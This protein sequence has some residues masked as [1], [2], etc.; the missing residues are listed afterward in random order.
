V[1]DQRFFYHS[2][3]RRG[4]TL[5]I[6]IDKGCKIL[7]A[8]RDFGLILVPEY[9]VW[10]QPTT[11]GTDRLFPILQKRVCFTELSP[12][13][14]FQH[15]QKF[16][17]FALEFEAATIRKLGAIPVFYLPQPLSASD[18]NALGVALLGIAMDVSAVIGRLAFLDQIFSSGG[19]VEDVIDFR[20]GFAQSPAGAGNYRLNSAEARNFLK[21]FGHAV[22]P[23]NAL[24]SGM[25]ALLNFFYPADDVPRDRLFDYYR[26]REWR[27][28]CAFAVNGVEVM[29]GLTQEEG[30]RLLEI[31]GD[32]FSRKIKTDLGDVGML[33]ATLV[34]PGFEGA[35]L[36]TMVRRV[37]VP[38]EALDQAK[39]ILANLPQP[40]EVVALAQ[41]A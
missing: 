7:A 3:P 11:D 17:Q 14:L 12:S 16:G 24:Q 18:G 38:A 30:N 1:T 8:I 37:I 40:P 39:A 22:A 34:L 21:A 19:P 32:F 29:R 15:A 26:Q 35:S 10:K 41:L 9:I 4:A 20:A 13:E 28:A 2:F 23:W 25:G 31:D 33:D 36:M 6:E 27:I 5:P